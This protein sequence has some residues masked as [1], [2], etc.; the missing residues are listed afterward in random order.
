V[1]ACGCFLLA[2]ILAALIYCVMH[3]LW[4]L[5]VAVFLVA[6]VLGW[7]AKKT[8]GSPKVK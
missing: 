3:G 8:G 7:L 2:G 6:V 1:C 5:A 4:L